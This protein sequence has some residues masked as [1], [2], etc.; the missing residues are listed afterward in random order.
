MFAMEQKGIFSLHASLPF[1]RKHT[2]ESIPDKKEEKS[3]KTVL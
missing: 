2:K 1:T 3:R